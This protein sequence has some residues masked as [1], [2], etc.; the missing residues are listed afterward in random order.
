MDAPGSIQGGKNRVGVDVLGLAH[1]HDPFLGEI[2]EIRFSLVCLL[3]LFLSSLPVLSAFRL[4]RQHVKFFAG[5]GFYREASQA[6]NSSRFAS[7]DLVISQGLQQ[8]LDRKKEKKKKF[9]SV[10]PLAAR[11]SGPS[12]LKAL[13]VCLL[14]VNKISTR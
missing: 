4:C 6:W 1:S 7:S 8:R 11:V 13:V 2:F 10:G 5:S 14:D 12:V 3:V 9:K